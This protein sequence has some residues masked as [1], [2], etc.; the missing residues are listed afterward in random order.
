[1]VPL[2]ATPLPFFVQIFFPLPRGFQKTC[3]TVADYRQRGV[4]T[5]RLLPGLGPQSQELRCDP[6]LIKAIAGG[7]A[8]FEEL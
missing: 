4:G 3:G 6:A 5:K 8:W 1:M 2:L 7:R